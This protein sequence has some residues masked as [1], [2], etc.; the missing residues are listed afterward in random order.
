MRVFSKAI[1]E[2]IY[3]D[4]QEPPPAMPIVDILPAR[5]SFSHPLEP[6][7]RN[8]STNE[9]TAEIIKDIYER[10]LKYDPHNKI[11]ETHFLRT[12]GDLKTNN[13]IISVQNIRLETG[14]EDSLPYDMLQWIIPNM[15]LFHLQLNLLRLIH[16]V[17]WGPPPSNASALQDRLDWSS[18]SWAADSLHRTNVQN[19]QLFYPLEE[20]IIH[21]YNARVVGVLI[22]KIRLEEGSRGREF[23]KKT[24]EDL[25]QQCTPNAYIELLTYVRRELCTDPPEM[26]EHANLDDE[27]R[28]H[29]LFIRHTQTYLLLKWAISHGDIGL[30]RQALRQC[31]VI[32]QSKQAQAGN[33]ARDLIRYLHWVDSSATD[34]VLQDSILSS[35]L[36]NPSGRPDGFIPVD[37]HLETLNGEIRIHMMDSRSSYNKEAY[38]RTVS[39]NQPF[40]QMLKVIVE[41]R[42]GTYYSGFHPEKEADNDIFESATALS[43]ES[44]Q[45][46]VDRTRLYPATDLWAEGLKVLSDNISHYNVKRTARWEMATIEGEDTRHGTLDMEAGLDIS[47]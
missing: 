13:R 43:E 4:M 34:K 19:G 23:S 1:E 36:V 10:Q 3:N 40:Y 41:R 9:N 28:N 45:K 47:I 42:F 21:S 25:L 11:F 26:D 24:I 18:L 20:L 32:F 37:R 12:V 35:A 5:R 16:R 33:Y 17:H 22:R 38:I 44:L 2:N 27:W 14:N 39:L 15:G 8:E 46:K 31:C 7:F 29:V 30:L 6:I